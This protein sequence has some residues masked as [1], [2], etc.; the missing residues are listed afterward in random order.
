MQE[1]EPVMSTRPRRPRLRVSSKT[2]GAAAARGLAAFPH[3]RYGEVL[4]WSAT[5]EKDMS[6]LMRQGSQ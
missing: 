3:T 5:L 2:F 6:P 4:S 1:Y